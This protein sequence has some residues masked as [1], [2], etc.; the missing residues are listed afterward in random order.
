[1]KHLT[2]LSDMLPEIENAIMAITITPIEI[3]EHI[4]LLAAEYVRLGM[5]LSDD[6]A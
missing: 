2:S 4:A 1:M 6:N 3:M 5:P